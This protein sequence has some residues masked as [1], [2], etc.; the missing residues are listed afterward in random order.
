[1]VGAT[2]TK[3]LIDLSPSPARPH[4]H[5]TSSIREP[6][7][8]F[9][10]S[11]RT[12]PVIHRNDHSASL[13]VHRPLQDTRDS[14]RMLPVREGYPK[15]PRLP[16]ISGEPAAFGDESCPPSDSVS[17]DQ[18]LREQLPP[19]KLLGFDDET[20]TKDSDNDYEDGFWN[21]EALQIAEI[22]AEEGEA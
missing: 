10:I 13:Q 1:M 16:P 20:V 3:V 9:N 18:V 2:P 19:R 4:H 17:R 11:R 22:A 12:P 14:A 8:I 6:D 7:P 5:S 15:S 21:E